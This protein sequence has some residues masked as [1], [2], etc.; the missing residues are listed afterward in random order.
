M[1]KKFNSS[2]TFLTHAR[3]ICTHLFARSGTVSEKALKVLG[4]TQDDV[5]LERAILVSPPDDGSAKERIFVEYTGGDDDEVGGPPPDDQPK[6][7]RLLGIPGEQNLDWLNRRTESPSKPA[8]RRVPSKALLTLGATIDDVRIEKAL[9]VLGEAPGR[10]I[11]GGKLPRPRADLDDDK[12]PS[13]AVASALA[14]EHSGVSVFLCAFFPW[15]VLAPLN[16][17]KL[18]LNKVCSALGKLG[19]LPRRSAE[20]LCC[21]LSPRGCVSSPLRHS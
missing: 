13:W 11:P 5:R 19:V 4:A 1:C 2:A 16:V 7:G 17:L 12:A 14:S 8:H 3:H 6:A 15:G 9:L 21:T 10:Q 18:Q 20:A